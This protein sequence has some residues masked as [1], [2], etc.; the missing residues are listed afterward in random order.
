MSRASLGYRLR[1]SVAV[2]APTIPTNGE[3]TPSYSTAATVRAEVIPRRGTE[4]SK[5]RQQEATTTWQVTMRART[6]DASYR[7]VW[8]AKTLNVV[9]AYDPDQRGNLVVCECV[10]VNP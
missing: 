10:E 9:S 3:T 4:Q 8:G 5:G 7:L 6:I 2:Q 1:E